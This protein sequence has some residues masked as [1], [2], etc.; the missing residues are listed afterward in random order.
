MT[1]EKFKFIARKIKRRSE[2]R[3]R[4][5][6]FYVFFPTITKNRIRLFRVILFFLFRLSETPF[7]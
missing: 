4:T 6:Y 1:F 3:C 5:F 7:L 2:L